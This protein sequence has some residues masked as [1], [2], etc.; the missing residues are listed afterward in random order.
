MSAYHWRALL[1]QWGALW[2]QHHRCHPIDRAGVSSIFAFG[3]ISH[4]QC[5]ISQIFTSLFI[6]HFCVNFS[7][8]SDE[9]S[10]VCPI[11]FEGVHCEIIN[12]GAPSLE[13][14]TKQPTTIEPTSSSPST[15]FPRKWYPLVVFIVPFV[16][17]F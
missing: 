11:G 13:P 17:V 6:F 9:F 16:E 1:H 3:R 4:E 15:P 5:R 2:K 14:T 7:F 8:S 12:T 10:C